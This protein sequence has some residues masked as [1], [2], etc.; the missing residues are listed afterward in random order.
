M[1]AAE[2]VSSDFHAGAESEQ[3]AERKRMDRDFM[4]PL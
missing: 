3:R 1:P 2:D 4:E